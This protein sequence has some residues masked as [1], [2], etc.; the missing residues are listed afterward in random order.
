M[1]E[2]VSLSPPLLASSAAGASWLL[3]SCARLYH[4]EIFPTS[5]RLRK[6][7]GVLNFS[8]DSA[9]ALYRK[10]QALP[11]GRSPLFLAFGVWKGHD[12]NCIA[13]YLAPKDD[14]LLVHGFDSFVG[15]PE[16]WATERVGVLGRESCAIAAARSADDGGDMQEEKGEGAGAVAAVD[17][18]KGSG[19][20][21]SAAVA[22][23]QGKF[24]LGGM[25][26]P[27]LGNVR[28]IKGWFDDTVVP[29][30][31]GPDIRGRPCAFVQ[32]DAD[33]YS[34]TVTVLEALLS[35]PGFIVPGTVINFDN[36]ANYRGWETGEFKA[37]EE[38]VE[39]YG[40]EFRYLCYHAPPTE[41]NVGDSRHRSSRFGFHSVTV[42]VT[43]LRGRSSTGGSGGGGGGGGRGAGGGAGGRAAEELS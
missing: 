43:D 26:P 12:A 18:T 3:P 11:T 14:S 35:R 24:D 36:Y 33:L 27:V 28:L 1:T 15:L 22:F 16:A 32:C 20:D 5:R 2:D 10:Q 21:K 37:W 17:D 4:D 7:T 25:L 40:I 6:R 23:P 38:A 31:D 42:V 41:S 30:L 39:R 19:Q 34:S 13:R 9:W 8:L 29:F